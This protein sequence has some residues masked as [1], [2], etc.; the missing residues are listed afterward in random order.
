MNQAHFAVRVG[1]V[2][3]FRTEAFAYQSSRRLSPKRTTH[4]TRDEQC[5]CY[6]AARVAV[7]PDSSRDWGKIILMEPRCQPKP[8]KRGFMR[9]LGARRW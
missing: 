9:V 5:Y 4:P 6:Q 8:K 3:P 7:K 1:T 2:S